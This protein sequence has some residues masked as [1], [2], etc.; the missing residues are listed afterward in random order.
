MWLGGVSLEVQVETPAVVNEELKG[1]LPELLAL[2]TFLGLNEL[3]KI[4]IKLVLV[5]RVEVPGA[6]HHVLVLSNEVLDE[7]RVVSLGRAGLV[8]QHSFPFS[9]SFGVSI[10][11][12]FRRVFF[13]AF[14]D[15]GY[16]ILGI[17]SLVFDA[18]L[19]I[20]ATNSG[21]YSSTL[22]SCHQLFLLS[23][24]DRIRLVANTA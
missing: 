8:V 13:Q 9:T 5:Y 6:L 24:N 1:C 3:V 10:T 11:V 21:F 20:S 14:A 18:R 23:L 12:S 16:L 19:I 4:L 22:L 2:S 15:G 17:R 7:S